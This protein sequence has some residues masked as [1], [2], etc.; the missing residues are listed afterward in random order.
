[1]QYKYASVIVDNKAVQ[2][3]KPFTYRLDDR[4]SSLVTKGMRVIVP[5]GRGNKNIKAIVVDVLREYE[6][7][8]RLKYV[9][10][11]LDDR[12]IIDSKLLDLSRWI[13]EYYL[14]SYL[15]ALNLVLPPGDVKEINTLVSLGSQAGDYR[16]SL[17]EGEI[18]N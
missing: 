3:D 13:S 8:Y 17:E 9:V 7:N 10:D 1:M 12:P 5:F 14:S 16:T 11:V 18:L 15:D 6:S 4:L 2:T